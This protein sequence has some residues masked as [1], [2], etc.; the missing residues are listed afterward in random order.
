MLEKLIHDLAEALPH[1]SRQGHLTIREVALFRFP[2]N[3]WIA[4]AGGH[5]AVM[6][7]E[8]GGDFAGLGKTPEEAIAICMAEVKKG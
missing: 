5:S 7:G 3:E 1:I 2:N 4:L 6:L 8:W